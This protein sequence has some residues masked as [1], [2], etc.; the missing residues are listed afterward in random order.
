LRGSSL[1]TSDD[2]QQAEA[3]R[4]ST[5]RPIG[6][7]GVTGWTLSVDG[8]R[9]VSPSDATRPHLTSRGPGSDCW[10]EG[11]HLTLTT[12]NRHLS[13]SGRRVV[14]CRWCHPTS[15]G[16]HLTTGVS[17]E[18]L[19]PG[20]GHLYTPLTPGRLPAAVRRGSG[21]PKTPLLGRPPKRG[22]LSTMGGTPPFWGSEGLQKC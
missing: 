2:R 15:V 8:R 3:L 1:Q 13:P 16:R 17:G 21:P 4:R 22:T 20:G 19:T 11:G 18:V 9:V 6:P 7:I 12:P 10:K 14:T 5:V